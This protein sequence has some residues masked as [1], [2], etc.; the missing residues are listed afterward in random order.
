MKLAYPIL[1]SIILL[2]VIGCSAGDNELSEKVIKYMF[3]DTICF[4]IIKYN[5]REAY[6]SLIEDKE[7]EE[8]HSELKRSLE[9]VDKYKADAAP[10]GGFE[11]GYRALIITKNNDTTFHAILYSTKENMIIVRKKDIFLDSADTF[12]DITVYRCKVSESVINILAKHE[13]ELPEDGDYFTS[14]PN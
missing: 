3:E 14:F 13:R 7:L 6:S 4:Q 1:L 2:T 9:I 8:I 5:S 11:H 12:P 10:F